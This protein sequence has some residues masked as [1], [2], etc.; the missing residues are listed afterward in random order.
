MGTRRCCAALTGLPAVQAAQLVA[1]RSNSLPY[2]PYA[3]YGASTVNHAELRPVKESID[4]GVEEVD[5]NNEE[6]E[7]DESVRLCDLSARLLFEAGMS[8]A[9][10]TLHGGFVHEA[11][12][13]MQACG[14]AL[15]DAGRNDLEAMG[16]CKMVGKAVLKFV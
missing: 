5:L 1:G 12:A 9:K 13:R 8:G 2:L 14:Q 3:P 7:T 11:D 4:E 16:S 6:V 15:L 10:E